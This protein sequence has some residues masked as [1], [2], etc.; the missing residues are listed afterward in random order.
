MSQRLESL[1][2]NDIPSFDSGGLEKRTFSS[3]PLFLNCGI[4][5][6]HMDFGSGGLPSCGPGGSLFDRLDQ[7]VNEHYDSKPTNEFKFD[8]SALN[9]P[10]PT[11]TSSSNEKFYKDLQNSYLNQPSINTSWEN[12][13]NTQPSI[14]PMNNLNID[15]GSN[16]FSFNSAPKLHEPI[17][18]MPTPKMNLLQNN[19]TQ[20]FGI[21][22]KPLYQQDFGIQNKPLYP[23]FQN[24]NTFGK[25]TLGTQKFQQFEMPSFLK[26]TPK[27]LGTYSDFKSAKDYGLGPG[28]AKKTEFDYLERYLPPHEDKTH[29]KHINLHSYFPGAEKYF[30]NHIDLNDD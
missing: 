3:G 14:T 18:I 10:E 6:N 16:K 26:E 17:P 12:L 20:N 4:A 9:V 23:S 1:I 22:Q 30:N 5:Y 2:F 13:V 28:I 25:D 7:S 27:P 19:L 29:G 11:P 21:E 15:Y 24:E 8:F